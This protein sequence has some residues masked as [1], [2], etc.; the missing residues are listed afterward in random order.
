MIHTY[1]LKTQGDLKLSANFRVREFRCPD[2]TDVV[3]VD[4]N[5][6]RLLQLLRTH[7][8]RPVRIGSGFRTASYNARIGGHYQSRHL[9]GQAADIDVIDGDGVVD[10]LLVAMTAQVVGSRSI[11]CYRYA[12]GRSW[13]HVGSAPTDKYWLQDRPGNQVLINTF[14]PVLR[15]LPGKLEPDEFV[16]QLQKLLQAFGHYTGALDG[17]FGDKTRTAVRKYQEAAALKIDGVC[18]PQTWASILLKR[19]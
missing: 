9:R 14:L 17:K 12:D 8:N 2:G 13:I 3:L 4:D 18:G 1:S 11:G 7:F 16:L 19:R 10:P 5:L 6:V 15:R